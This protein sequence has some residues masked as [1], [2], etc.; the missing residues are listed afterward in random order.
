MQV[1][2][3]GTV[4]DSQGNERQV[5]RGHHLS[6]SRKSRGRAPAV[7]G[8]RVFPAAGDDTEP[9]ERPHGPDRSSH[10]SR[11]C[12]HAHRSPGS[13]TCTQ[14][15]ERGQDVVLQWRG[16]ADRRCRDRRGPLVPTVRN[17]SETASFLQAG[18]KVRVKSGALSG[19][20]GLVTRHKNEYRIVVSIA[21]IN[22]SVAVEIDADMLEPI[23]NLSHR[24]AISGIMPSIAAAL[25]DT[26]KDTTCGADRFPGERTSRISSSLHPS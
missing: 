8:D 6:A 19:L 23:G 20:E 26:D 21:L 18:E 16:G 1:L 15:S 25:P 2:E 17:G 11:I 13:P 10:F 12:F 9:L 4:R 14:H 5:V 3:D 24:V 7:E 22:Q